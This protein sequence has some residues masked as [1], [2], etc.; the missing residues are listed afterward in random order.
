MNYLIEQILAEIKINPKK[1]AKELLKLRTENNKLNIF[2]ENQPRSKDGHIIADG[3]SLYSSDEYFDDSIMPCY[4]QTNAY[5][6]TFEGR[7]ITDDPR[8][9]F[10]KLS[11]AEKE[12]EDVNT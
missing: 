9:F 12:R 6:V 8:K 10:V 7:H 5:W 4:A 11:N 1:V 2:L 3:M